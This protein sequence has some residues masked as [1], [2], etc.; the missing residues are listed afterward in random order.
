[1]TT[2][3][4]IVLISILLSQESVMAQKN[5]VSKQMMTELEQALKVPAGANPPVHRVTAGNQLITSGCDSIFLTRQSEI[6]SFNIEHPGCSTVRKI[7]INGEGASPAITRLDSLKYIT[8]IAEELTIINTSVTSLSVL[9]N[10]VQI[11]TLFQLNYNP[12]LTSIGLNNLTQLG[13]VVFRVNPSLNSIAGLSNNLDTIGGVL[14]DTSALTSLSGLSGIVHFD[15]Y[16]EIRNTP[17]T[18]LSSLTSLV[19]INGY[20]RLESIPTLT[21]IGLNGL[22]YAQGFLF[23]GLDNLTTL[24]GLTNDLTT[25]SKCT[26]DSR[27]Y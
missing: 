8:N 18:D 17:I 23:S 19:S 26:S 4:L 1:M 25:T 11:G 2:R 7:I 5:R 20:L 24:A 13:K 12:L 10:L 27:L 21:S 9:P 16:L 15:G 14:I 6:D 22:E 3:I